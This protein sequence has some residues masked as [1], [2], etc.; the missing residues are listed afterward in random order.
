VQSENREAWRQRR[1]GSAKFPGLKSRTY[2]YNSASNVDHIIP[3]VGRTAD[4]YPISGLHIIAN[5]QYL[6]GDENNRKRA[7]MRRHEQDLCESTY[8]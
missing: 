1:P 2:E 3:L 6:P 4:G 8:Y 5:L 7:R